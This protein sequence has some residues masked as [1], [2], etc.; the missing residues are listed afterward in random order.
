MP[1]DALE[2][3]REVYALG[4]HLRL[5][6]DRLLMEAPRPLPELVRKAVREHKPAIM[7]VLG[8]PL[9]AVVASILEEVRPHLPSVLQDLP[10][11]K[12][13]ALVN[14]SIIAAWNR[15]LTALWE[16]PAIRVGRCFGG[17]RPT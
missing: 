6:G 10:D 9:D 14:W 7:V 17:P 1:T 13:L 2:V 12:L 11:G 16:G 8:A 4:G 15:A 5:E 3:I